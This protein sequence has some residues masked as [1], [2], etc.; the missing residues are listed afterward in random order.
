MNTSIEIGAPLTIEKGW[1]SELLIHNGDGYCVKL[2][3]FTQGSR[4]SMHFHRVKTE[5]WYILSGKIVI[6]FPDYETGKVSEM[7]I[8]KGEVVHLPACQAHQV[9]A[10]EDTVIVEGSTPHDDA[11]TYRIAPGDSQ[12]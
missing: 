3:N 11:D 1:G 2:L 4:G 8:A 7:T 6:S 5:T 12:K 10:L 9:L